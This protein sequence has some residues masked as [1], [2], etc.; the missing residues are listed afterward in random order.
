MSRIDQLFTQKKQNILNIYFTA[1]YPNLDD[2]G[3][4]ILSLEKA[5]VDLIEIGMPYSDPLADGPTIQESGMKAIKNGMTLPILFDQIQRVRTKT[6]I[7][8]IMMGYFNQI[9]QYG[10][11]AFLKKCR[12]V[13]VDGL[14]LPDLPL[15]EYETHFKQRFEN[16][17]LNI[18]FLMTPQ[19]S[20]AR[21]R[22]IDE[23][24]R[25]FIY[26]VSSASITGAKKGISSKQ[27]EYFERINAMNLKNPRLIGF[28]ISDNETFT[29]AC[30]YANGAII[31]SAY[32]RALAAG[33]GVGE[34]TA[35]FVKM[36]K[37]VHT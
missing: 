20:E 32:I 11:T 30:E 34:T 1:G 29:K 22:K 16:H 36:V 19:T 31:G 15:F 25:G 33:N 10:E 28:G 9:M 24:T 4:I 27:I 14:I 13:G 5:G 21:I 7:P 35:E 23:L 26:M 17:G 3:D 2:T 18:S 8:L 12:E 6:D 37:T